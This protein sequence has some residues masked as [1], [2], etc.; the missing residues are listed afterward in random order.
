MR[1][2]LPYLAAAAVAA[3]V[4]LPFLPLHAQVWEAQEEQRTAPD[5]VT[6][7]F[8]SVMPGGFLVIV[9]GVAT[10]LSMLVTPRRWHWIAGI[11]LFGVVVATV[12]TSTFRAEVHVV[13]YAVWG[14]AA[15]GGLLM[16]VTS[17]IEKKA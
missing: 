12:A 8:V 14:A 13:S 16:V 6:Q 11:V 10:L 1:R 2:A 5:S 7:V 17:V 4:L 15:V 9:L 3:S